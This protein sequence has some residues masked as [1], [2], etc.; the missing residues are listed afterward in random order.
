MTH[1]A[2][3]IT[4]VT[5]LSL[6]MPSFDGPAR[7]QTPVATE[8]SRKTFTI[9]GSVGAPGIVMAGL[10]GEPITGDDGTYSVSVEDGWSGKATPLKD[11]YSFSP[12]ARTY[13]AVKKDYRNE[14][15]VARVVTLTISDRIAL[16]DEPISGVLITARPGDGSAVTD[17]DG[18]YSIGVPYGWTGK[19]TVTK[20]GFE[21]DPPSIPYNDPV[22][23]DII[24]GK[25]T[26]AGTA[27]TMHRARAS[28][29]SPRVSRAESGGNVLVIPTKGVSPVEFTQIAEDMRVMLNILR[30]KLSEPRTVRGVLYDYGDFFADAGRSTEA[31]YLQGYAAMFM[32]KADF[33]LSVPS[34]PGQA[35]RQETAPGDPVWQRAR[36]RLYA[37]HIP[38]PYGPVGMPR[39]ADQKSL[40]QLK[41][42]LIQTLRHAAN[43]RNIDPNEWIILTVTERSSTSSGGGFGGG[44]YSGMSM[45][46]GMGG[47]YGGT[48]GGMGGGYGG[49]MGGYGGAYG[50][51][52]MGVDPSPGTS[53][54]RRGSAGRVPQAP[55]TPAAA[56][57]LTIQAKKSDIDAF[58]KGTL[59][60]DQFRR[61]VKVFTY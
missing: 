23:N 56:T 2:R 61:Q 49:M 5:L 14:D 55:S 39:E 38:G 10:P 52:G 48:M 36:D 53:A 43:I 33:P 8:A 28:T 1:I 27:A 19:L 26:L 18:R 34:Q 7:S 25:P 35:E 45:M 30:E 40:D 15:Y 57:A 4:A 32:L 22:T 41:E 3:T 12:P 54:R 59:P 11:G 20:D 29:P 42:D 17:M 51:G 9:S 37:P 13:G 46:G 24:D 31:L 58:S 21:F 47:G 50:S 16:G 60:P 44:M 6:L